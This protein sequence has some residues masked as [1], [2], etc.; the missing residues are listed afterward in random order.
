MHRRP[1]TAL[2]L[3]LSALLAL[4]LTVSALGQEPIVLR[5]KVVGCHDGDSI[6]VLT[7]QNT[8]LK[9]RLA[10]CDAPELGSALQ[11]W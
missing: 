9:V 11:S 3:A 8:Q 7:S 10:F 4:L 5:G 6:T 1:M 2:G